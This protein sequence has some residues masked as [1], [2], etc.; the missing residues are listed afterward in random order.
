MS[1]AVRTV[2]YDQRT[3]GI[4]RQKRDRA[5]A[6]LYA[7]RGLSLDALVTGNV[8]RGDVTEDSDVGIA[9]PS[10]LPS[11]RVE[12]ALERARLPVFKRLVI[13]TT[14][15]STPKA[16]ISLDPAGLEILSFPLARETR[17]E[18]EF[19][20]FGGCVKLHQLA[21]GERVSGV[22]RSLVLIEPTAE[23]HVES[24]VLGKE[25][26]V[27]RVLGIS[28]QTVNEG[29][30]AL[31]RR[32]EV[33]GTGPALRRGLSEQESFEAVIS[34]LSRQN[35]MLRKVLAERG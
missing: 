19:Q 32:D 33:G 14:P 10:K 7:L 20:R 17:S 9:L 15:T 22:N 23:G 29:I 26:D 13:Q 8:A 5:I 25:P 30:R 6:V 18:Q 1:G 27:A 16:Y 31:T 12:L 24:S 3:W 21:R 11:R 4:L 2:R 35:P 28:I 34:E